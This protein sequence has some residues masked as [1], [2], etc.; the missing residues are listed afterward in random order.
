VNHLGIYLPSHYPTEYAIGLAH[1]NL[2]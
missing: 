1:G 2:L